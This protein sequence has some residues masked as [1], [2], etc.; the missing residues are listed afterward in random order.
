MTF[1][2]HEHDTP[3]RFGA[4][5]GLRVARG[6]LLIAVAGCA[7]ALTSLWPVPPSALAQQAKVQEVPWVAAAPGRVEP[8]TGLVRV[9]SPMPERISLVLVELRDRVEAGDLLIRLDDDEARARLT[10]AEAEVDARKKERDAAPATSGRE[11]VR[12]AEDAIYNAE[13]ALTNA[14]FALDA[15]VIAFVRPGGSKQAMVDALNRLT[16]A[17]ERLRR[18]Q[19]A[20][21][22]AQSKS[23]IPGPNRLEAGLQRARAEVAIADAQLHKTRIRAP[24]AGTIL[25]LS[26]K[27][28]EFVTPSPE[29]VLV[30]L[31]D[32]STLRVRAEVDEH[33]VGKIK[34]D[35]KAFVKSVAFP[36]KEFSG[37]VVDVAPS[38]ALPRMTARGPRRPTDVEALEVLI[39]LDTKTELLPGMRVDAYFKRE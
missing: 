1:R 16:D 29:Q 23:N 38:L 21:A 6:A 17:R 9:S 32:V 24:I 39:E 10:G 12:R 3:F 33:D 26:A 18:E 28:G 20:Y 4:G 31:G 14:R 36:G 15:A 2:S 19:A 30:V 27:V 25:Q 7:I 34:L 22:F 13:R 5:A 37:K 35:G 8:R 11:D